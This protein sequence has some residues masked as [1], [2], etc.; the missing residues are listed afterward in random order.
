MKNLAQKF[1]ENIIPFSMLVSACVSAALTYF[2][3]PELLSKDRINYYSSKASVKTASVSANK[4]N[5]YFIPDFDMPKIPKQK[6]LRLPKVYAT[7]EYTKP[8][9]LSEENGEEYSSDYFP[10]DNGNKEQ[11]LE[12]KAFKNY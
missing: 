6:P 5:S 7:E 11:I 1:E 10:T 8:I 9:K 2:M 4:N 12:R 3:F